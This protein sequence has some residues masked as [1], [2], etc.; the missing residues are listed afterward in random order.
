[1]G[2]KRLRAALVSLA[3]AAALAVIVPNGSRAEMWCADPLWAHE[4]GVVV[5]RGSGASSAAAR[6]GAPDPALP[7]YFHA[8]AGAPSALGPPVRQ[9]PVD[10]GER[11]LPIVHFY[12]PGNWRPVPVGLEVGFAHGEATRWFPQVDAHRRADDANGAE[13]RRGRARLVAMRRARRA[14]GPVAAGA[15]IARDPTR[16]LAWDHLVL[17]DAPRQAPAATAVPWVARL[18]ALPG[19]L[20][21]NA[22]SESERFVFYE[23]RTSETPAIRIERGPSYAAG[24]RH[25]ILRNTG[26][27]AV[28][29]V[30]LVHREAS[31]ATYV[32][33]VPSI[34]AGSTAGYVLE[35]H[36]VTSDAIAARTRGALRDAIVD[37]REPAPPADY[38]WGGANGCVMQRD[39]AIPVEQASDHR[40]YAAEADVILEVWGA[41]FF[42]APGT[43]IVYRED[44]AQLDAEMPLSVYTDM[45]HQVSLRRLGLALIE[46]VQ[47][48]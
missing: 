36:A 35:D 2:S 46:G 48:P 38:R 13:A 25:L 14:G 5:F 10:G 7:S 3:A 26:A 37:A 30:F 39:P 16:Q 20:W 42:D 23:G 15:P 19:A 33:A 47:L 40:V 45:Y 21:V 17:E 31:G 11:E 18:R 6:S 41:R 28:H 22:A 24:R 32:I 34:P 43:T 27:R 9:L 1:M 4:W 12:A 8:Q 44:V 29:D